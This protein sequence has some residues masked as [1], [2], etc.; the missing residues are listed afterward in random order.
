MIVMREVTN[1]DTPNHTYI[2]DNSKSKLLGYIP[3]GQRTKVMFQ[4]PMSFS[5]ARRKFEIIERIED[6]PDDTVTKITSE[7]GNVYYVKNDNGSYS[8]SC[9]GF[10]YHG[11]CKHINQVLAK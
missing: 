10:K 6:E 9:I 1:W 5:N 8:C 11:K 3:V 2:V 7:S 4:I